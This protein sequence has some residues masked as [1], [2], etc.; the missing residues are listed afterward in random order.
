MLS[1]GSVKMSRLATLKQL[2]PEPF[3][4]FTFKADGVAMYQLGDFGTAAKQ[5]WSWTPRH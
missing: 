4:V 3:E 2:A 1:T 5:L